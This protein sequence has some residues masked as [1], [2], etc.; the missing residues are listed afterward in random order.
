M[1]RC[2]SYVGHKKPAQAIGFLGSVPKVS[3]C[4]NFDQVPF[5][6][7]S[8]RLKS[9]TEQEFN[10]TEWKR[11]CCCA[12]IAFFKQLGHDVCMPRR[13]QSRSLCR[14]ATSATH[15]SRATAAHQI[16]I[17][18]AEEQSQ[19]SQHSTLQGERLSYHAFMW[20]RC[21]SSHVCTDSAL[22]C[23]RLNNVYWHQGIATLLGI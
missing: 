11:V 9:R 13:R 1:L 6:N 7:Q 5:V 3:T 20:C 15:K 2:C 10:T 23:D 22:K 12:I 19:Q 16:S 8:C 21:R 17:G 18:L 14:Y 4:R